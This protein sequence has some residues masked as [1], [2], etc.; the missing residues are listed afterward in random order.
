MSGKR[1][2]PPVPPRFSDNP[3]EPTD[4][5]GKSVDKLSLDL[6]FPNPHQP[7][8][9]FDETA[10]AELA[11]SIRERGVMEPIVVRP[12]D[13]KYEIVAGER[14]FRASKLAGETEIPAIVRELSD[15]DAAADA[16]LENF[17]REDLT[18]TDKA[19]ALQ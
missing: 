11:A 2:R 16:L 5:G 6:V 9:M 8:K 18:A 13:G 12:K 4:P 14:R 3:R 7:R 10:L 1:R 17:Q 15:E 19:H